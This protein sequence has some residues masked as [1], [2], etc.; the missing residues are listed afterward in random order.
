LNARIYDQRDGETREV[1]N[2]S[3]ES[4]AGFVA[5][6]KRNADVRSQV[7][8]LERSLAAAFRR[9]AESIASIAADAGFDITGWDARPGV[10]EPTPAADFGCCGFMTAGTVVV[11]MAL[12][13]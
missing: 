8:Q 9:E 6:L 12:D 11:E 3:D 10:K 13:S 1:S 4:V 7:E 2:M 5:Y